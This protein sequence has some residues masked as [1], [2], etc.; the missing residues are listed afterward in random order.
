MGASAKAT[1][2][3]LVTAIMSGLMPQYQLLIQMGKAKIVRDILELPAAQTVNQ[4]S[5]LGINRPTDVS[6]QKTEFVKTQEDKSEK[7]FATSS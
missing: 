4:P 5:V 7:N 2:T 6:Q 3:D 1:E